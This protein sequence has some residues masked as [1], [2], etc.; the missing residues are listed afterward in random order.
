MVKI[1]MPFDG[2]PLSYIKKMSKD[3]FYR[4][5]DDYINVLKGLRKISMTMVMS[6]KRWT[7]VCYFILNTPS[8]DLK[9]SC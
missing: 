6:R 9:K 5:L 7:G 2:V 8:L 4:K 3:V 1:P